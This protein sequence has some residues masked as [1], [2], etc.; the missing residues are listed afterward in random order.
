MLQ[1]TQGPTTIKLLISNLKILAPLHKQLFLKHALAPAFNW[2][3]MM[4]LLFLI[5]P[6]CTDVALCHGIGAAWS[7]AQMV[8][9][10]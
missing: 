7:Q 8:P 1:M 2:V 9:G 3:I 5:L 4:L 10:E 6:P